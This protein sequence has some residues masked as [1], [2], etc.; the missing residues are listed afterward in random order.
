MEEMVHAAFTLMYMKITSYIFP[1][2]WDVTVQQILCKTVF[3]WGSRARSL[4]HPFAGLQSEKKGSPV[5]S[6]LAG[7]YA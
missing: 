4:A 3:L 1:E 2:N 5:C 6:L 7:K